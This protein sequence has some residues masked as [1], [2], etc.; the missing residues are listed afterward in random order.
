MQE[1]EKRDCVKMMA[2]LA[3][4]V[5]ALDQQQE[6]KVDIVTWSKFAQFMKSCP[7]DVTIQEV[8]YDLLC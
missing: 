8:T 1:M 7:E 6:Q 3:W 2:S 5:M 4:S